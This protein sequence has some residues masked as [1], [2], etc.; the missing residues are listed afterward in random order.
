MQADLGAPGVYPFTS[1]SSRWVAHLTC[2]VWA[3]SS[4]CWGKRFS[5]F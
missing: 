2:D 4:P 5:A 3:Q 1:K